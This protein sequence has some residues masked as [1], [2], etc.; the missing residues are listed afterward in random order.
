M[1]N[2]SILSGRVARWLYGMMLRTTRVGAQRQCNAF[3]GP[4]DERDDAIQNVYVINLDRQI[5]RWG[6]ME[7][8]LA[9]IRTAAST[10]LTSIAKRFSAVDAKSYR[11]SPDRGGLLTEY[12]L[13][14]Q[15]F[16]EPEPLLEG[17]PAASNRRVVM[18]PQEIAVALSHLTLWQLIASGDQE[19]ALI[20]EDDVYFCREFA[21]VLNTAWT[22]LMHSTEIAEGFDVLYLSYEEAKGGAV[23]DRADVSEALFRPRRGLWYLSGYVLSRAGARRLVDLF[24]VCGPVDLWINHQFDTLRV[25]A[26]NRSIIEQRRDLRSA[27]SYSILPVLSRVGVMWREKPLLFKVPQLRTPVFAF[28]KQ[29][30]GV[31]S[32]A[33]AL[34]M[35]GYRCISNI[36]RLPTREDESLFRKRKRIFDAYVNV[37]SLAR[38]YSDLAKLYPKAKFIVTLPDEPDLTSADEVGDREGAAPDCTDRGL[39][40][41]YHTLH[42]LREISADVLVLPSGVTNRWE[43]LCQFLECEQPVSPYPECPDQLPRRLVDH[44]DSTSWHRSP[45]ITKLKWDASPWVVDVRNGWHGIRSCERDD[46]EGASR[47][48]TF[49]MEGRSE[50]FDGSPWRLLDDTFPSNLALFDPENFSVAANGS[51]RLTLRKERARVREYTSAALC[52]RERYTHGRFAAVVQSASAPGLVT[53]IFLHRN[54]PRQEIDIELLGKD[55]T[56]MLVNVYYNPGSE[57]AR[58]EYGYRGTPMLI[59]LGFDAAKD[60]HEYAIEWNSMSIR[61]LVDGEVVYERGNWDPTPIPHLPMNFNVNLWCSRSEQLAG[62]LND[63]DLPAHTDIEE[64]AI[65]GA[66]VSA[67]ALS[68]KINSI[69]VTSEAIIG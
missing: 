63:R 56:K 5:G 55:T 35:L 49:R 7:R 60:S 11:G 10:P 51:A 45:G 15:L 65:D 43:V 1:N 18:T 33:M 14:D 44:G 37:G 67:A 27:N 29:G 46:Q 62:Q 21:S 48:H 9:R 4:G 57:G 13:G 40:E 68:A 17:D 39:A 25:L 32:L 38:R 53:G 23:K 34:S 64:L 36:D 20:L 58:M 30:T 41:L 24:P 31:A 26:T 52:S 50:D 54:A 42:K 19:Y 6:C 28:G 69:G 16:V 22:D 66:S 3:A 2:H 8:E 59:D 47:D 61:W 12:S